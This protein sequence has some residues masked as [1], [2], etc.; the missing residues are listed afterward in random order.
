M[1]GDKAGTT[2]IQ[3]LTPR[4]REILALIAGGL[5]NTAIRR[6]LWISEKTMESHVGRIYGKLGLRPSDA[7]HRRVQAVLL[8]HERAAGHSLAA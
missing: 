2:T 4:E 8:W 7:V 3:A 6:Q 5:S 1:S